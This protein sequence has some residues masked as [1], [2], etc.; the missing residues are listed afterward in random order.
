M[1]SCTVANGT[2]SQDGLSQTWRYLIR[3]AGVFATLLLIGISYSQ[4]QEGTTNS[5]PSL[6]D[7]LRLLEPLRTARSLRDVCQAVVRVDT[8]KD[9]NDS[10]RIKDTDFQNAGHCFGYITGWMDTA[11]EGLQCYDGRLYSLKFIG[12]LK[13]SQVMRVFLQYVENHPEREQQ[14]AAAVLTRALAEKNMVG[15]FSVSFSECKEQ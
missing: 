2:D 6:N 13:I 9:T 1:V 14:G 3:S 15:S 7:A 4:A 5:V 11:P 12:T 10:R 8:A